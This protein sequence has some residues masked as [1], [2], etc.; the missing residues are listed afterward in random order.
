MKSKEVMISQLADY[1][2]N[3]ELIEDIYR[4]MGDKTDQFLYEIE[5][6]YKQL[7][8]NTTTWG[9]D[10][11]EQNMDIESN[12]NLLIKQRRARV[13][14]KLRKIGRVNTEMMEDIL[15]GYHDNE[16]K[17][18]F[19]GRLMFNI[20]LEGTSHHHFDTINEIINTTKPAHLGFEI[21]M[22][23][24]TKDVGINI[25]TQTIDADVTSVRPFVNTKI[26]LPISG[27][28]A[29]ES[30]SSESL[31]VYPKHTNKISINRGVFIAMY[32]T[33]GNEDVDVYP[34]K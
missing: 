21:D 28:Y 2:R 34:R 11:W 16:V 19:N 7:N 4:V 3:N 18:W 26:D 23:M 27:R 6:L 17:V 8:I 30:Y 33:M 32:N 5:D 20:P 10:T 24:D 25:G 22:Y 1:E 15:Q 29:I 12:K 9:I 14:E 13:K 31:V